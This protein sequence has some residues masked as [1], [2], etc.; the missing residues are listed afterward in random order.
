[1]TKTLNVIS[2][3]CMYKIKEPVTFKNYCKIESS[4]CDFQEEFT[5]KITEIQTFLKSEI[6]LLNVLIEIRHFSEN[7]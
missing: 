3:I 7:I 4:F 2:G 1:M 5:E 6:K